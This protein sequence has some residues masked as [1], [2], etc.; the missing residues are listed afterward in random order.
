M[1]ANRHMDEEEIERYSMGAMPQEAIVPFEEHLLICE[2]CQRRLAETDVYVSSMERASARLRREPLKRG[3]PWLRL[4]RLVSALAGMAVLI[5]TAGLWFG[6]RDTTGE[7]LP[8]AVN[9]QATR[10]AAIEARAPAGRPLL[11]RLDLTGLP[12]WSSYRLEMVDRFG[13]RIWQATV[14]V[15]PLKVPKTSP[16]IYLVR[17]YSPS[18]DLLREYGL[19]VLRPP[20]GPRKPGD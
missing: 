8:F 19:E 7:T 20:N 6:R 12:V 1:E 13:K 10:G 2:S 16:G 9:L 3:L 15:Q 17:V 4:P 18:G 5:A 11:L 14:P